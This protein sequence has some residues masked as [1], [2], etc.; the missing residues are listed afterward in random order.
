MP[1]DIHKNSFKFSI[2][3]RHKQAFDSF[4]CERFKEL[5]KRIHIWEIVSV[6]LNSI[7]K[8]RY[9]RWGGS[10]F[11]IKNGILSQSHVCR[12]CG[13]TPHKIFIKSTFWCENHVHT[14]ECKHLSG[15]FKQRLFFSSKLNWKKKLKAEVSTSH[16]VI[17]RVCDF[18]FNTASSCWAWIRQIFFSIANEVVVVVNKKIIQG[19]ASSNIS[20]GSSFICLLHTCSVVSTVFILCLFYIPSSLITI[21]NRRA[22]EKSRLKIPVQATTTLKCNNAM[23]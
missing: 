13:L 3:R 10:E 12:M 16:F 22:H 15:I 18:M 14:A 20:S 5:A 6:N 21:T 19:D 2:W 11:Q 8:F 9:L 4:A 7:K 17:E 23:R 1:S